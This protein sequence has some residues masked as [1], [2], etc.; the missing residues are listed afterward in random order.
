M[1]F[2]F[3]PAQDTFRQELRTWLAAN[4]PQNDGPLRHLQPQASAADLTFLKDWQRAVFE[5]GWAGISWPKE[6]GGRGASLIERMIFDE[7]MAHHKAPGLLNVL[8]LEIVGPTIIVHGTEAQKKKASGPYP[9]RC[10]Y[11]EPGLFRAQLGL[12]PGLTPD[13][14]S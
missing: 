4:V 3:T 1:D 7:E 2:H 13:A 12:G 10:G 14:R 9:E 11:L 8:G 6:Y 5:G